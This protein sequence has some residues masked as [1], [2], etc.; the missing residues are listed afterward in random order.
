MW[1]NVIDPAP[2]EAAELMHEY[3]IPAEYI[4]HSLDMDERARLERN[5]DSLLIILRVPYFQDHLADIPY[6]TI[7]LGIVVLG[8]KII[9]ICRAE[10]EV[11]RAV[12]DGR[13]PPSAS[14]H[15][16]V[17]YLFL[18]TAEAYLA[19]LQQ[20]NQKVDELEDRLQQSMRNKELTELLKYQKSL[21]YFTTALKANE[22]MMER[23]QRHGVLQIDSADEL[24][25]DVVV[26]SQQ[27]AEIT[28]VAS[29]ILSQM[30]DAFASIISNNLNVV[31]EFLAM[32]T[33][34]LALP[35]LV[36]SL[37]GMNVNLPFQHSNAA[38]WLILLLSLAL[39]GA[40]ALAFIKRKWM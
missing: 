22:V 14:G 16:F 33:I 21:V 2:A 37:Y 20:I 39:S 32:I 26:E 13:L 17:L 28:A 7:P 35:T 5:G 4:A 29:N 10:N 15:R 9:T 8:E 40:V 27:A 36:A 31:M 18:L 3:G 30:M 11:I 12:Y 1:I 24:W 6:V 38:F 23:L 19:Y 34:I 25:E